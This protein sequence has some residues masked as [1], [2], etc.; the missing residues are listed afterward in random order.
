VKKWRLLWAVVLVVSLS[1]CESEMPSPRAVKRRLK[2]VVVFDQAGRGDQGF[3]DAAWAGVERA[4]AEMGFDVRDVQSRQEADYQADIEAA[5]DAAD[6]VVSVGALFMEHV[7]KAAAGKPD[8]KFIH[9]EGVVNAP[10]VRV[11]NFRSEHGGFLVGV[12]AGLRTRSGKIGA[13]AGIEIPPVRAYVAGFE[14]GVKVAREILQAKPEAGRL[15]EG[16][17]ET[18]EVLVK[19]ANSFDDPVK[20]KALALSLIASGADVLFR[21]AGNTGQGV[22]E[23]VKESE[24]AL[25]IWEDIDRSDAIPD[26]VVACALKRIDEAVYEGLKSFAEGSFEGGSPV[27]GLAEEGIGIAGPF[28]SSDAPGD[29]FLARAVEFFRR[30]VVAGR[31][32]VPAQRKDVGGFDPSDLVKDF[33]ANE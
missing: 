7:A 15:S 17:V 20:G 30:A 6:I 12:V 19:T 4:A 28:M 8:R 33:L 9:I 24:D 26:R 2:V 5:A 18:M 29:R 14:A 31:I 10:N 22:Y 13:V 23:A 3:N 11:Y 1:A 27:L 32:A 25:L 16:K 21:V